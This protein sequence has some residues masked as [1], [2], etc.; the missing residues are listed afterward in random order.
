MIAESRG[1][2]DIATALSSGGLLSPMVS[3]RWYSTTLFAV[4]RSI[5]RTGDSRSC[6]LPDCNLNATRLG[7]R[8]K[9]PDPTRIIGGE[10]FIIC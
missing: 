5:A 2:T 9:H 3:L 10:G 1:E 6:E 4:A 8:L 7:V